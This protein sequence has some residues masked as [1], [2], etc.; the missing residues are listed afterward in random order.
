M[1]GTGDA[2]SVAV[3]G[4]LHY[5]VAPDGVY[6]AAFRKEWD[7]TGRRTSRNREFARNAANWS[8]PTQRMLA[9]SGRCV[10]SD[11]RFVLQ[12]GDL[13]QGDCDDFPTHARMLRDALALT[14]GFYPAGL[15]FVSV[16]GNHD[17]RDGSDR[18]DIAAAKPYA[19]VMVPFCRDQLGSMACGTV[20]GTTFGFR[21]GPDLYVAVDYNGGRKVLPAVRRILDGNRD[22]R[23]TF[24]AVHGGVF[25]FNCSPDREFFLGGKADDDV[26]REMR[27][28]LAGRQAIVLCGHTHCLELKEA[29]FPEGTLTEVTMN[30][31][32]KDGSAENPAMP[33]VLIEG[34]GAYG[35]DRA[36]RTPEIEAMFGEYRPYMTRYFLSNAVGH[37][38]L[39]VSDEGVWFDYFGHD[40]LVPTRTFHLR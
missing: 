37:A 29:A 8:G 20:D 39:R 1:F 33:R 6:H 17:I 24:V 18:N 27:A 26:R 5:D 19:E 10:T 34:V 14:T 38:R 40:A 30:T 25:P 36:R 3:L 31:V 2:Y 21:C 15:P 23:Y 11:T 4:D 35:T 12:L 16:C 32:W 13:I 22:V 9:A 7:G 28:L